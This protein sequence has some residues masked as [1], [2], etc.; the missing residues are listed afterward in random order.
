MSRM[1]GADLY[2][3]YVVRAK[4]FVPM[5]VVGH[6]PVLVFSMLSTISIRTYVEV[7][8]DFKSA[9][10]PIPHLIALIPKLKPRHYSIASSHVRPQ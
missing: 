3:S 1:E 8:L 4:R 10:P 5:M 9:R 2:Q 7:L 6:F